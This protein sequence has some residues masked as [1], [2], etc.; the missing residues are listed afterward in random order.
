M[1]DLKEVARIDNDKCF[2]V[3][4]LN[5][6]HWTQV[7]EK[8]YNKLS[9]YMLECDGLDV[10]NSPILINATND[11]DQKSALW[12]YEG[13]T[14]WKFIDEFEFLNAINANPVDIRAVK[15]YDR[16]ENSISIDMFNALKSTNFNIYMKSTSKSSN[17]TD[18][19]NQSTWT[20]FANKKYDWFTCEKTYIGR[21]FSEV[22]FNGAQYTD[23]FCTM[24]KNDD[25][26]LITITYLCLDKDIVYDIIPLGMTDNVY[27]MY[28]TISKVMPSKI[29]GLTDASLEVMFDKKHIIAESY[30]SIGFVLMCLE[31]HRSDVLI[32]FSTE[33]IDKVLTN[34]IQCKVM[35]D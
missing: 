19:N 12:V 10:C 18:G 7:D 28:H 16:S 31:T 4:F 9:V 1:F 26:E 22:G 35:L 29:V 13:V 17:T 2:S 21:C 3:K 11:F 20:S 24:E 14:N 5:E 30:N 23:T 8:F 27:K 25:N 33:N 32:D 15:F 34:L 6:E